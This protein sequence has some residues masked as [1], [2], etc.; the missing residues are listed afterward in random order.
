MPPPIEIVPIAVNRFQ[1]NHFRMW[2]RHHPSDC[3]ANEAP[4]C[5]WRRIPTQASRPLSPKKPCRLSANG[6][7]VS[8]SIQ[9]TVSIQYQYDSMTVWLYDDTMAYRPYNPNKE[10]NSKKTRPSLG[11]QR[12]QWPFAP[13]H[14]QQQ[15]LGIVLVLLELEPL[16]FTTT[17][18]L[19][20]C[21]LLSTSSLL[22]RD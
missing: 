12:S 22:I 3:H 9:Y 21:G 10:T 16:A 7:I 20:R 5:P 8:M 2:L 1:S 19:V 11:H 6:W 17:L 4:K 15:I 18:W 13:P 14:E